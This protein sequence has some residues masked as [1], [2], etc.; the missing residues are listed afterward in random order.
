M[1]LSTG[2]IYSTQKHVHVY[3]QHIFWGKMKI[4]IEKMDLVYSFFLV[5]S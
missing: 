4:L 2:S 3:G 1:Y 5:T